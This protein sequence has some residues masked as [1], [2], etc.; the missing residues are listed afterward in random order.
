MAYSVIREPLD[1]GAAPRVM[2]AGAIRLRC[3]GKECTRI[4]KRESSNSGAHAAAAKNGSP[5]RIQFVIRNA[6]AFHHAAYYS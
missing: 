2:R 1:P 3:D 4:G 6:Q 5:P